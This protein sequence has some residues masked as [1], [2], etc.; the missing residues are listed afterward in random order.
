VSFWD[1]PPLV[2][3]ASRMT[4]VRCYLDVDPVTLA[5]VLAGLGRV[6]L[7]GPRRHQ[8]CCELWRVTEGRVLVG[9]LEQHQ[10]AMVAR[11]LGHVTGA[12]WGA[13]TTW[14]RQASSG[15]MSRGRPTRNPHEAA[16]RM[17]EFFER[18]AVEATQWTLIEPYHELLFSVPDVLY[19]GRRE[20]VSVVLG[21]TTD[22]PLALKLDRIAYYGY[23]KHMTEFST[24]GRHRWEVTLDGAPFLSAS[25]KPTGRVE[26]DIDRARVS[27]GTTQ[28][29]LG[30]L[31]D[32]RPMIAELRRDLNASGED[33]HEVEGTIELRRA[34]FPLLSD[35][36]HPVRS[37][38]APPTR[39]S[40]GFREVEAFVTYPRPAR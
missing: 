11:E 14:A 33:L 37:A 21:M 25:L 7:V 36:R 20:P 10:W 13:W 18:Q 32:R 39:I 19:E 24:D 40:V 4:G 38:D 29:L 28:P 15:L 22:L 34:P 3:A 30:G 9:G 1:G 23:D 8:V 35:G 16:R 17:G 2:V 6:E 27:S 26:A 12:I 5:R 31:R